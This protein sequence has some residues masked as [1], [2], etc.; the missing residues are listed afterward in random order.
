MWISPQQAGV[1]ELVQNLA[2]W[3]KLAVEACGALAIAAGVLLVA[4]RWLRQALAGQHSDYNRL[5][6]T[7]ARFLAL[8]LELQLAADILSTAVAP[9][10]TRSASSAPSPCCAPRSI[11]SWRARS[12]RRRQAGWLPDRASELSAVWIAGIDADAA[13]LL[14]AL[15]V[16]SGSRVRPVCGMLGCR[17]GEL[18]SW[19]RKSSSGSN[20]CSDAGSS[21]AAACGVM[22]A[23]C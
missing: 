6:L 18:R 19:L 9:A 10:G 14:R 1:E 17:L 13:R 5:R 23:I 16:A 7:F 3:L 11:T 22:S 20:G 8:A 12:A 21:I 15:A 2:L 4:G